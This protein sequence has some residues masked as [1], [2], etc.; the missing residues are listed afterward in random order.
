MMN[1]TIILLSINKMHC[2]Y[3]KDTHF[4]LSNHKFL[5]HESTILVIKFSRNKLITPHKKTSSY[6][7]SI[8]FIRLIFVFTL[9][10]EPFIQ[11]YPELVQFYT[12]ETQATQ[13]G[14]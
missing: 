2:T 9:I 13:E 10:G 5:I 12:V 8:F 1:Y 4:D 6:K 14:N 7:F 3:T 11:T